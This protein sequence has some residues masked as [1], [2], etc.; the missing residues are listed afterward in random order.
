LNEEGLE[1]RIA[2]APASPYVGVGFRHQPPG[3][4]PLSGEGA[5]RAGGRCNPPDSFPVLY[6]CLST[7]CVR[8][9]LDRS[10]AQQ[11]LATE[12][13]LPRELY[14]IEVG[15]DRVLDLRSKEVRDELGVELDDL[16]ARD[17]SGP[18]HIGV[19]AHELN[20]QALILPSATGVGEVIAVFVRNIGTGTLQPHLD[21]L[22]TSLSDLPPTAAP[23]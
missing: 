10:A 2:S 21:H 22:W 8:A 6:L 4:D 13:L 3:F 15:L 19:L 5:R 7:S 11:G 12:D 16:L 17:L 14:R 18:R 1:D 23:R 20:I 9:E